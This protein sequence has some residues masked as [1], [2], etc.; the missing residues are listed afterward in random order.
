MAEKLATR[1]QFLARVADLGLELVEDDFCL[2]V[3]CPA[4]VRFAGTDV[5]S[6]RV[7]NRGWTRMQQYGALVDDMKHGVEPC[8]DPDCDCREEG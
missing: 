6:F 8:P 3:V 2:E 4:G 5:H 1:K 7:D